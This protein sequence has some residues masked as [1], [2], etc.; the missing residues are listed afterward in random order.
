MKKSIKRKERKI[1]KTREKEKIL[2]PRL[3]VSRGENE[4]REC[5]RGRGI[6]GHGYKIRMSEKAKER[7]RR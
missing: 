5:K 2:R 7:E 3:T 4:E 6:E 1:R